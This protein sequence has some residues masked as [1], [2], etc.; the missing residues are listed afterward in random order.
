MLTMG[1]RR[2]KWEKSEPQQ[3]CHTLTEQS[4]TARPTIEFQT[5][6]RYAVAVAGPRRE[7]EL[8]SNRLSCFP[9]GL[10]RP[11]SGDLEAADRLPIPV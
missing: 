11:A 9:E 4:C 10:V 2:L 1:F 6:S 3:S 7:F 8:P 5:A